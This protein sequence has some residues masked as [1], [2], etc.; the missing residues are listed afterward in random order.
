MNN[1]KPITNMLNECLKK[2]FMT[3]HL[4]K[5]LKDQD[6]LPLY[7]LKFLSVL[8]DKWPESILLLK[9]IQDEN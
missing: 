8:L 1:C 2:K 9:Q 3:S 5:I 6:P 4:V 7:G